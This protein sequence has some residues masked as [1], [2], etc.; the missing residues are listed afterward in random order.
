MWDKD[1]ILMEKM[2]RLSGPAEPKASKL[3]GALELMTGKFIHHSSEY[4]LW[5]IKDREAMFRRGDESPGIYDDLAV[6]FSKIGDN[7]TAIKI[8]N[9]KEKRHPGMYE[10]FANLGTFYFHAG[11]LEKGI[12]YIRKALKINPQAHFGREEYQLKL[13]EY[14][15][16]L[17][18]H[19]KPSK[20]N[21][22]PMGTHYNRQS[23]TGPIVSHCSHMETLKKGSG[24]R[25]FACFLYITSGYKGGI[26]LDEEIDGA[27]QGVLG[28]MRFGDYTS[29]IL[30]EALGDLLMHKGRDQDFL[31]LATQAYLLASYNMGEFRTRSRYRAYARAL[32]SHLNGAELN[33]IE[34]GLKREINEAHDLREEIRKDEIVW[35]DKGV[36]VDAKFDAKYHKGQQLGRKGG[37][38]LN[39]ITVE[40]LEGSVQTVGGADRDKGQVEDFQATEKQKVSKEM[41]R[42]LGQL[43][44]EDLKAIK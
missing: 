29:P 6:G 5:R 4:Y 23:E 42:Y 22:L 12:P 43:S 7:K 1:T 21:F 17:R 9:I 20:K 40:D 31:Q 28:M 26:S 44:I 30:L 24:L 2:G 16:G 33:S 36:D 14:V 10:T 34:K 27:I 41:D 25:G 3:P 39:D 18:K 8:M 32:S 15:L 38:N 13:V 37:F 19:Y 35:I 11:E